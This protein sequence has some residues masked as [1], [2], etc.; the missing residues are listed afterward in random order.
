MKPQ[1]IIAAPTSNS[2][3]TTVTLGLL[4]ALKNR[5]LSTQPFKVGPDYIDPK[6]HGIASGVEGINLD[7]F[8]MD[9]LDIRST[10]SSYS[11][12][13]EV[14]VVEG[15]MGLFDGAKRSEKS[16]AELAKLLELPIIF[17]VD[18]KSVAYSVAPLLYGFKNF[19]KESKI[20]GVIFNRVNT[21]SHY[22]F[23]EE[24]CEDVGIPALGH[25]PFLEDCKIESRHL[26]LSL[27]KIEEN[28]TIIEKI[29]QAIEQ[30]IHVDQ[31]LKSTTI[32][33][34]EY[35]NTKTQNSPQ[36]HTV[37]IAKD[38]AFNFSYIQ[39]V[40]AFKQIGKIIFFS[41]LN[42]AS[43][44]EADIVYLPGGYPEY[45]TKDLSTNQSMLQSIKSFADAGGKIIA[46]CG[47]LMYLGKSI[48]DKEGNE[49][50]MVNVFDYTT[51]MANMK[52]TLGYRKTH[53][54]DLELLGHEF[55]Y[56]TLSGEKNINK[57]GKSFS[58][59]GKEVD[60]S[61]FKYKNTIASYTHYYWAKD[62]LLNKIINYLNKPEK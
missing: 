53:I 39:T 51:S 59:R 56:S 26:G 55:H 54:D 25:L 33:S 34:R 22:K 57:V 36:D 30:N 31:L 19:D 7:L 28:D 61:F 15:V 46:E 16:T 21:K 6:F 1:F 37:A 3:K 5:G 12:E 62:G 11:H 35:S 10:Y 32:K 38:E 45:F 2:G 27:D 58:A 41:P 43:L 24:A 13:T 60:T 20:A 14:V 4:R 18:A 8:M 49:V 9:E 47:G 44:P 48:I 17:V 52:L 50:T 29:A 40:N 23:L 42:D